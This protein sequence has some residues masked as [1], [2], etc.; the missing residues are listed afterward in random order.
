ML[1]GKV[2]DGRRGF[3]PQVE[4]RLVMKSFQPSLSLISH[5][6]ACRASFIPRAKLNRTLITHKKKKTYPSPVHFTHSFKTR[7]GSRP[8]FWVLTGSA[9]SFFFKKNQNDVVL[10]KKNQ[11]STGL[12]LGLDRVSRLTSGFFFPFFFFNPARFQPRVGWVSGQPTRPGRVSKLC[13]HSKG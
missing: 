9:G 12:Q 4:K 1:K 10:V 7:P 5:S 6:S 8:G 2:D 13:F 3:V 11:K